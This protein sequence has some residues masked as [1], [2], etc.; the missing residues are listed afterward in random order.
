MENPDV[1]P[2]F[3]EEIVLPTPPTR[4]ERTWSF[5]AHLSAL[6]GYV[7]VPLG[8]ILG[9]LIVW[10]AKRDSSPLIAEQAREALNFN[11]SMMIYFIASAPLI[12]ILI[13]IPL[14]F[15]LPIIGVVL[16]IV[17]TIKAADGEFFSY[18]LTIR[19]VK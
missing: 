10:L 17:A 11:I 9:P 16:T 3:P 12:F 8:N 7:G 2:A 13:G 6:S 19:L 18:P 4:E 15:V 5:I 1:P 14:L